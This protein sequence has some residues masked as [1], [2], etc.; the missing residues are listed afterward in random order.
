MY[1]SVPQD[2][3]LLEKTT[4]TFGAVQQ[5]RQGIPQELFDVQGRENFSITYHYEKDDKYIC[6]ISYTVDTKSKG[7]KPSLI[8]L[9]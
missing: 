6:T 9:Q 7:K 8:Y 4:T 2:K 3:L 1:A 5:G